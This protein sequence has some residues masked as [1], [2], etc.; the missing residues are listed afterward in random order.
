MLKGEDAHYIFQ[1][2][3]SSRLNLDFSRVRD[4]QDAKAH[5]NGENEFESDSLLNRGGFKTA[6]K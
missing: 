6:R 4:V 5:L 2:N 1:L 3:N